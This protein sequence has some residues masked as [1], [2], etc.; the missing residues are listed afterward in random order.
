MATVKIGI[1]PFTKAGAG[2]TPIWA[3]PEA[4]SMNDAKGT[5][6][7]FASGL[8]DTIAVDENFGTNEGVIVGFSAEPGHNDSTAATHDLLYYPALPGS[9][10]SIVLEDESNNNHVSLEADL[11]LIY[12]LQKD[13]TNDRWFADQNDVT[14]LGTGAVRMI[15]FIDAVGTTKGLGMFILLSESTIWSATLT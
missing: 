15:G 1:R 10:W 2:G 11:G 3:A 5:P 6:V 8:L 4:A 13:T 14:T 7:K 12:A 9:I